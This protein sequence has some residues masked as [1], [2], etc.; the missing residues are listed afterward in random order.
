MRT[1]ED[2]QKN[3]AGSKVALQ[4]NLDNQNMFAGGGVMTQD[5]GK[6]YEKTRAYIRGWISLLAKTTTSE[7]S[8][9]YLMGR[10]NAEKWLSDE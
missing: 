1:E 8:D 10:I 5:L 6:Q 4:K 9:E 3:I 2:V 7:S